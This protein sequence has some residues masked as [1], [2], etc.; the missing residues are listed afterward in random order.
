MAADSVTGKL[1]VGQ[2]VYVAMH[3]K[4]QVIPVK[5]V[6]ETMKKTIDG[7]TTT[8]TV[9]VG[10]SDP[11]KDV[12]LDKIDGDVFATPRQALE[13]LRSRVNTA[14]K[15]I[16]DEATKKASEWYG[17]PGQDVDDAGDELVM[18]KQKSTKQAQQEP[19]PSNLTKVT[20]PDGQVVY[21]QVDT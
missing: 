14:I 11:P 17:E 21:A 20:L 19:V 9:R 16:V 1:K 10:K 7:Q 12:Q 15:Q 6:E 3:G 13:A 8:Y 5:V 18:V 2:V 4:T